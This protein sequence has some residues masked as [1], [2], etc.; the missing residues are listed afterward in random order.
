MKRKLPLSIL[1]VFVCLS[2]AS[3]DKTEEKRDSIQLNEYQNFMYRLLGFDISSP[4]GTFV[5]EATENPAL[6][7]NGVFKKKKEDAF[8]FKK[9]YSGYAG[10]LS[11]KNKYTPIISKH[12]WAPNAEFGISNYLFLKKSFKFYTD[13]IKEFATEE[14]IPYVGID[15]KG[16]K[17]GVEG[18]PTVNKMPVSRASSIKLLWVSN[19]IGYNYAQ[20]NVLN[21]TVSVSPDT[22]FTTYRNK[23]FV[24]NIGLN[25]FWYPSGKRWVSLYGNLTY[26][27]KGN[28]NNYN[29]L[30][31]VTL[32]PFV[33]YNNGNSYLDIVSDDVKGKKGVLRRGNTDN[34]L[35]NMSLLITPNDKSYIGISFY[36]QR[37]VAKSFRYTDRGFSINVPVIN[38]K[39]D[40]KTTANFG[41]R[42]DFPDTNREIDPTKKMKEKQRVGFLVSLPLM[43]SPKMKK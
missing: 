8:I 13:D 22:V 36:S 40:K 34:I 17:E 5:F 2:A 37:T 20:L 41:L 33:R 9:F 25:F 19:F 23:S 29:N 15:Q 18:E 7:L 24:A 35:Y 1:A 28:D 38:K 16:Q 31:D 14:N 27:Y 3:Q 21:S 26:A 6:K 39:D 10:Q 43:P 32:K 11:S 4:A 42:F 12:K 30:T